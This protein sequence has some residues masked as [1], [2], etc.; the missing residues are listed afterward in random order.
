VRR[1]SSLPALAWLSRISKSST[2]I[3]VGPRV[4]TFADGIAEGVWCGPFSLESLSTSTAVFGS[5]VL[6][7]QQGPLYIPPSHVFEA[8]YSLHD[9]RTDTLYVSNSLSFA[10]RQM[11]DRDFRR[12]CI[13]LRDVVRPTVDAATAMGVAVPEAELL[14]LDNYRLT[15]HVYRR[16]RATRS[17]LF[18]RSDDDQLPSF[19]N[20]RDYRA[21][22]SQSLRDCFAN[23]SDP[24]RRHRYAPVVA[25]SRGYDSTAVAVLAE[26]NGCT[27]A[28]TL[29]VTVTGTDDNGLGNAARL[30]LSTQVFPHVMGDIVPSLR[31]DF[32]PDLASRALEFLATDGLGDDVMFLPFEP[33]LSGAILLTGGWG[34]AA[35]GLD[36]AMGP[37]LRSRTPFEKSKTEYRLRVGFAQVAVPM[38]GGRGAD[39]IAA[40]SRMPEMEPF[41]VGGPYDRPI[42]RRIAEEAGL[43]RGSFATEKAA[44]APLPLNGRDYYVEALAAVRTRYVAIAEP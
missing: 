23:G 36:T 28:V 39:S 17:A 33:A 42:P 38:I 19:G 22:L 24:R 6:F 29:A 27:R 13:A 41:T 18:S 30:G 43:A 12:F 14:A 31:V 25:L 34:D 21:F 2:T 20:Y 1:S 3:V 11:P 35:W 40:I 44:T 26:E 9:A 7:D 15:R 10:L 16:F 5:G 37:N 32:P 8:L 4:E